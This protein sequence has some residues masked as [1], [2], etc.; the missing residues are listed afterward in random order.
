MTHRRHPVKSLV[1]K[2]TEIVE[3]T[4]FDAVAASLGED[5][6]RGLKTFVVTSSGPG[7]GKSTITANLGRAFARAGRSSVCIVDTDRFRPTLHRLFGLENRRGLGELLTE[8]Y[9]IE[10]GR[11]TPSQFGIGDWLEVLEAQTRSGELLVKDGNQQFRLRI[12]RGQIRSVQMPQN[13]EDMRLGD[14]LV[15]AGC[16]SD[17]QRERALTL[18][19]TAGRPLGE[20]LLSL[21]YLER[22]RLGNMLTTQIRESLR[23]LAALRRPECSFTETAEAYLPATSGQSS[24]APN[25]D[26]LGEEVF[27]QLARY[28][29]RPFLTNQ[30]PSFLQD[31]THEKLKVLTAGAVPYT[32]IDDQFSQPFERLMARLSR[33]FD[34]VLIDSPPVAMA[35]PAE[36]LAGMCDGVLMV[37]KADGYDSRIVR[38]AKA[39]LDRSNPNF[40]GVVLNHVDLRHADPLLHYYGAYQH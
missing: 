27:E 11:E 40:V 5:L 2:P 19:R 12:Q 13:Q 1:R 9:H 29:K 16:I 38:Q 24:E 33:M 30:I 22:D 31:T 17:D 37:V 8:L 7:E 4:Y 39:Q 20:V 10:I 32:L 34:I 6:Q 14:M 15:A 3:D 23:C 36:M 25:G 18:Q 35:S 21:G 28:L 26:V